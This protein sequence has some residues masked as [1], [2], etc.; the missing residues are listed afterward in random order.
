[1]HDKPV[2]LE[3]FCID[4]L[5]DSVHAMCAYD[6]FPEP[7]LC[8]ENNLQNSNVSII[9]L[10]QSQQ[11]TSSDETT[12]V[13]CDGQNYQQSTNSAAELEIIVPV[14]VSDKLLWRLCEK[15]Q[16]T[17]KTMTFFNSSRTT[18]K[19]VKIADCSV[20][21][22]GLEILRQHTLDTL[23]LIN[24]KDVQL[25]RVILESINAETFNNLQILDLTGTL[26]P[27]RIRNVP[28]EQ[29]NTNSSSTDNNSSEII[30]DNVHLLC[31]FK[32]LKAL[33]VAETFF[34]D[35]GLVKICENLKLIEYLDISHTRVTDI[36]PLVVY[37]DQLRT[38]L[39]HR[40]RVR[41]V[42]ETVES[43]CQMNVLEVLDISDFPKSNQPTLAD[44]CRVHLGVSLVQHCLNV[45]DIRLKHL[46]VLDL[47]GS[48]ANFDVN[49]F[50]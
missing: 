13:E 34:S 37:S 5:C 42:V 29:N 3:D 33:C 2:S 18:L 19:N 50:R 26:R 36:Q 35:S 22:E 7:S 12:I 38:L 15:N 45:A 1:M 10:P 46:R 48:Q 23:K 43:L 44:G 30:V 16:L 9:S 41:N 21:H 27:T 4:A 25:D 20:N 40:P 31:R 14:Y 8:N 28:T 17:N 6:K 39:M 11:Y 32:N 49:V 47:S 24:L